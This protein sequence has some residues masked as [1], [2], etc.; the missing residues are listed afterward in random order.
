MATS[1]QREITTVCDRCG[2]VLAHRIEV[3]DGYFKVGRWLVEI[4]EKGEYER[5]ILNCPRL[6]P[7]VPF[8]L[9]AACYIRLQIALNE[10]WE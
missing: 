6:R 4:G 3:K 10:A 7:L 2:K 9:C 5:G 8:D 1:R